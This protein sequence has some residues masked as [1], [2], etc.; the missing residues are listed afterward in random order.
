M[1]RSKLVLF[2]LAFALLIGFSVASA[3]FAAPS[4]PVDAAWSYNY[5]AGSLCA[6]NVAFEQTGKFKE[7]ILPNNRILWTFPGLT[8]KATNTDSVPAKSVI[9]IATGPMHITLRDGGSTVVTSTGQGPFSVPGMGFMLYTGHFVYITDAN[10]DF[11]E[12]PA[13]HGQIRDICA[14]ID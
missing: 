4:P 13:G 3:A 14:L 5:S 8:I 12:L 1:S 6:F 10:G 9:L 11:I 2:S 7:M